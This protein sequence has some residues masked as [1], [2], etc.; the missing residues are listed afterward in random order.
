MKKVFLL[1][2]LAALGVLAVRWAAARHR[3]TPHLHGT[4]DHWPAVV[5]RESTRSQPAGA[6]ERRT[7]TSKERQPSTFANSSARR[8]TP[9]TSASSAS[10]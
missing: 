2:A 9:S 8:V 1:L 3:T 4:P 5:R 6:S 10:A 7:L